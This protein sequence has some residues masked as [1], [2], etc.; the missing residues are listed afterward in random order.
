MSQVVLLGTLVSWALAHWGSGDKVH[1]ETL[2]LLGRRGK[3]ALYTGGLKRDSP[4]S[5][6]T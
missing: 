6:N 1:V 3:K 5:R 4:G 2:V